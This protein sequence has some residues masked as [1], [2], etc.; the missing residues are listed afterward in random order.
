MVCK[1]IMLNMESKI[2]LLHPDGKKAIRMDQTKYDLLG[3][4]LLNHL[5]IYGVQPIQK[6]NNR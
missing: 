6:F 5:K 1:Q 3:E 2:Q 4:A